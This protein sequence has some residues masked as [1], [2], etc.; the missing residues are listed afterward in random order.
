MQ[1]RAVV[2]ANISPWSVMYTWYLIY[3][4]E[5][6]QIKFRVSYVS[7]QAWLCFVCFSYGTRWSRPVQ[8]RRQ[9][10]VLVHWTS[11]RKKILCVL[12][13][14]SQGNRYVAWSASFSSYGTVSGG[15]Q[16]SLARSTPAVYSANGQATLPPH[17]RG[18]QQIRRFL[19]FFLDNKGISRSTWLAQSADWQKKKLYVD[20]TDVVLSKYA[21]R[22]HT[23]YVRCGIAEHPLPLWYVYPLPA[24]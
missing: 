12:P 16:V 3:E 5:A 14:V 8:L 1:S 21:L 13:K 20:K 23:L 17:Q 11:N 10:G 9:D 15:R 18:S 22:V 7:N 6:F 2:P 4:I 19:Y 24:P